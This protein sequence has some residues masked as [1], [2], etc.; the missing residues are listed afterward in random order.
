MSLKFLPCS[1]W[2]RA[3]DAFAHTVFYFVKL[4]FPKNPLFENIFQKSFL[5]SDKTFFSCT[6]KWKWPKCHILC[7]YFVGQQSLCVQQH[8]M[9]HSV[10]YSMH[11]SVV[12]NEWLGF[13]AY[14]LVVR[15]DLVGYGLTLIYPTHFEDVQCQSGVCHTFM[16]IRKKKTHLCIKASHTIL[17]R[18]VYGLLRNRNTTIQIIWGWCQKFNISSCQKERNL[19]GRVN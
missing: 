7:F 16:K 13:K 15:L 19:Q 9:P 12:C 10:A 17:Q 14:L 8:K 4:F 1:W 11:H 5:P 6:W 18:N 2:Y 3:V